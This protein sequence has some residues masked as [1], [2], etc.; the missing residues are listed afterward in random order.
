MHHHMQD[1]LQSH[2]KAVRLG[3]LEVRSVLGLS[4]MLT[5]H[6]DSMSPSPPKGAESNTMLAQTHRRLD[7]FSFDPLGHT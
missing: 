5:P 1:S 7:P 6:E 2:V 4:R 3:L